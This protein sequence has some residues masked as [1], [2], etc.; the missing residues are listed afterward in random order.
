M[1]LNINTTSL[2]IHVYQRFVNA[3]YIMLIQYYP[4]IQEG[5]IPQASRLAA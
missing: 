3:S 4:L 5:A 1:L 2:Y